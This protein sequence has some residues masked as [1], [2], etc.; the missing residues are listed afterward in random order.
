MTT[1]FSPSLTKDQ[2]YGIGQRRDPADI[3]ALLWEIARL[4][5]VAL[6]ADQLM[7]GSDASGLIAQELR[8]ELDECSCVQDMKQLRADIFTKG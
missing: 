5:A 1:R 7:S 4:R 8:R 3:P 2:L 6:R